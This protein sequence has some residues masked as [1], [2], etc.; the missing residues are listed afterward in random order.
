MKLFLDK[1]L[2]RVLPLCFSHQFTASPSEV[3]ISDLKFIG[4]LKN[5]CY[6]IDI[7][8]IIK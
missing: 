5:V 8:L 7:C 2:C 1:F 4:T 6:V 3:K